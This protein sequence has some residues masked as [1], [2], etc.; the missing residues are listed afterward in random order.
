MGMSPEL[1][2]RAGA[3]IGTVAAI[4]LV[5]FFVWHTLQGS[6]GLIALGAIREQIAL[7]ET[8]L[9]R[10]EAERARLEVRVS[11]LRAERLDPD[12]L[13]ERARLMLNLAG[14]DDIVILYGPGGR[15]Y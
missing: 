6:R 7:A 4:A 2:R 12:A 5:G 9:A 11:G 14:R 8:E 15:L 3:V 10:L 1:A 13:D